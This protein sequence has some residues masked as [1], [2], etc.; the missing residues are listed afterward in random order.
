MWKKIITIFYPGK[1]LFHEIIKSDLRTYDNAWKIEKVQ[2]DDNT[3][4]CFLDYPYFKEYYEL[5]AIDLS[6]QQKIDAEPKAI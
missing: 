6:K 1:N 4:G 5:I 3:T 2:S